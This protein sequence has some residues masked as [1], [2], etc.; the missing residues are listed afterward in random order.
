MN[1]VEFNSRDIIAAGSKSFAAAAKLFNRDIRED[2]YFLYA[3]CRHCDDEIDG[4]SLGFGNEELTL[5]EQQRRLERIQKLTSAALNGQDISEPAF[6]GLR[7][8]TQRHGIPPQYPLELIEGFSMDVEKCHY[9]KIEDTLLYC[10]HVAGVVGI[11]MAHIMG[12]RDKSV[13]KRAADLGIAFQLT[14]IARDVMDDAKNDRIYLP[15]NWLAD[16]GVPIS[17]IAELENRKGVFQVVEKLLGVADRYYAS[18]REGIQELPLSCAWAISAADRVYHN[19]G[20]IVLD[21]GAKAW[22]ERAVAPAYRKIYWVLRSGFTALNVVSL[23]KRRVK[24][25]RESSLWIKPDLG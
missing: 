17:G 18:A 2:V 25:P 14:N 13:L 24:I 22:D 21:R 19:I 15:E 4:Q 3:W 6:Q 11:M 10:Y 23:Q 9:G 7:N 16:A 1:T 8:V 12:V 20:E 5:A